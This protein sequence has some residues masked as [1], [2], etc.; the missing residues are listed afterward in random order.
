[1]FV[2]KYYKVYASVNLVRAEK[3]PKISL[4]KSTR[5]LEENIRKDLDIHD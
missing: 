1:M 5:R 3:K 2:V 4:T